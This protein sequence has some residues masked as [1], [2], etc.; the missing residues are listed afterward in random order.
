MVELKEGKNVLTFNHHTDGY[1]K[2][3]SIHEFKLTP[4]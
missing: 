3:F 2:G 1:A 4:Q